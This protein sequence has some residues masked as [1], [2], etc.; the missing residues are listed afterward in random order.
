MYLLVFL[1]GIGVLGYYLA[2]TSFAGRVE[3]RAGRVAH[4]P[5]RW[6]EN[7][8]DWW[9]GRFGKPPPADPFIAWARNQGFSNFPEDFNSWLASLS[10][11]E[12]H[13]FT[14]ALQDYTGGLGFDLSSLVDNSLQNKP[15]LMQVYVEAVVIYSQAYR[16]A[17]ETRQKAEKTVTD[18]QEAK[19]SKEDKKTAE[20]QVSRRRS[21]IPEMAEAITTS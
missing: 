8:A 16:R 20:K 14:L 4:A 2:R 18:D 5:K 3:Q 10:P 11:Q 9:R 21:E 1:I 6:S 12:S 15:A 17:K 19:K 13:E 7:L